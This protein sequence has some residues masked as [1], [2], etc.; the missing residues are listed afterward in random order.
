[1][2]Y[3]E[4]DA[5][6]AELSLGQRLAV[7]A[8]TIK[9]DDPVSGSKKKKPDAPAS[10]PA[11]DEGAP[12]IRMT[13]DAISLTRTLTQALHSSDTRLLESVLAHS[14][15]TL[16]NNTVR[17]LPPQL[18]VPLLTACV[19]RLNRGARAGTGKGRGDGSGASAQ[20]GTLMVRWIRAVLVGHTAYLMTVRFR[21][22]TPSLI[23][24]KMPLL[25]IDPGPRD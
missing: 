3:G 5:E 22:L 2:Q 7:P 24:I 4:L 20:R 17:R 21:S 11:D 14:S 1:M 6:L 8:S 15:Q 25:F 23:Y 13:T 16:I 10:K 12:P 19:E 18:A 9:D